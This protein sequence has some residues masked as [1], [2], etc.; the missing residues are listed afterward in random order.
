MGVGDKSLE[1]R[2]LSEICP[3]VCV[4]ITSFPLPN[5]V[6]NHLSNRLLDRENIQGRNSFI[7]AS[8][9]LEFSKQSG[10]WKMHN[11]H[12]LEK[13]K[14]IK[15]MIS[16]THISQHWWYNMIWARHC[17]HL[18]KIGRSVQKVS[19]SCQPVMGSHSRPDTA[20]MSRAKT[21][22]FPYQ[23]YEIKM[24]TV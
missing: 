1:D 8:I 20:V 11:T 19:R 13:N 16:T 2:D 23:D 12:L 22:K 21:A 3:H 5:Q 15:I 10:M 18:Q 4:P 7:L 6:A 14:Q 24:V 17:L 9:S